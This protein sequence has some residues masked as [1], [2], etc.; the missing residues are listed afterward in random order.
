[1]HCCCLCP[2]NRPVNTPAVPPSRLLHLLTDDHAHVAA[3]LA[4]GLEERVAEGVDAERVDPAQALGLDQAAL[5][6]RHDGPDVAEGDAGKQE[7]PEQGHRHAEDG[8]QHAVAPVLGDGEGGVAGLPDSIQT[9][10]S[11][12]FSNHIFKV[13]LGISRTYYISDRQDW[14]KLFSFGIS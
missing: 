1:M 5:D 2:P 6:A 14:Q 13:H 12:W 11:V 10:G 9:V 7:A 4:Q 8:R 3:D